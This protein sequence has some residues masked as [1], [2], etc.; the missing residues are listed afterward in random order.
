MGLLCEKNKVNESIESIELNSVSISD[1]PQIKE[2]FISYWGKRGLYKDSTFKAIIGQK[3]SYAYKSKNK[4]IAFCLMCYKLR[5]KD[6]DN[7]DDNF[8]EVALLCVRK[9]Y[10]NQKLGS[11]LLSFCIDNCKKYNF[12]KI[13]LHVSTTNLPAF[14]L[15]KKLGFIVESF[16]EKYYHDENPKDN[17]AYFMTKNIEM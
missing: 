5:K 11:S 3:L 1:I 10:R 12:Q 16:H 14:S 13:A 2:I 15:Y 8:V 17:D 7:T 4:V 6:N 9:E